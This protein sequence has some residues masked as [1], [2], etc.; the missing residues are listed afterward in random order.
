[1]WVYEDVN[2]DG[3]KEQKQNALVPFLHLDTSIVDINLKT[4][5]VERME[6]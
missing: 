1:M 5:W 6:E 3:T 2:E 4:I